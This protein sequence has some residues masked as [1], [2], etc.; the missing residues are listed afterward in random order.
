MTDVLVF[1]ELV[2]LRPVVG[3]LTASWYFNLD[4][5]FWCNLVSPGSI[6][7]TGMAETVRGK[8]GKD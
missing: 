1:P 7:S 5:K 2:E 6:D 3:R 4:E 8:V